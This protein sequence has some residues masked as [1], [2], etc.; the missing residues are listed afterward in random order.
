MSDWI[1]KKN[2]DNTARFV[3]GQPGENNLICIGVNPSTAEPGKLDP[4]LTRVSNFARDNG[5]DG[6]IM[7]NLYPQRS[8]MP[9]LMHVDKDENLHKLNL[10]HILHTLNTH[11]G[12]IWAAWGVLIDIRPYL[13]TCLDDIEVISRFCGNE[14][15]TIGN[16]TLKGHPRHPLYLKGNSEIMPFYIDYYLSDVCGT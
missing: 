9:E 6:W 11:K 16:P 13:C 7:L 2:N 1:Y 10:K 15:I 3:L 5:F 14:W 12:K 4:T 8:T